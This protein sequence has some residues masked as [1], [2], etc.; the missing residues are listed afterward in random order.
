M[1]FCLLQPSTPSAKVNAL[2]Y[3]R[4][5]NLISFCAQKYDKLFKSPATQ[6]HDLFA[7]SASPVDTPTFA[8]TDICSTNPCEKGTEEIL[9]VT[10]HI[11]LLECKTQISLPSEYETK[12]RE[13]HA[14][15]N[16]ILS[17]KREIMYIRRKYVATLG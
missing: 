2:I 10:L 6:W 3:H 12:G 13:C 17:M 5:D 4:D 1:V 11:S 14:C 9:K 8:L 16:D 15:S 7:I